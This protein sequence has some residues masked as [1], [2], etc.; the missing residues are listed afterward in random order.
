MPSRPYLSLWYKRFN[1][2]YSTDRP[3]NHS[4][5]GRSHSRA[6]NS[7]SIHPASFHHYHVAVIEYHWLKQAKWKLSK[8]SK[9]GSCPVTYLTWWLFVYLLWSIT[10]K[11]E[12]TN[13]T[14][15]FNI[16]FYLLFPMFIVHLEAS[17][18]Y[19]SLNVSYAFHTLLSL[20]PYLPSMISIPHCH[21]CVDT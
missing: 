20:S 7:L 2:Y 21:C 11:E 19:E 3:L 4:L 10:P 14:F 5:K 12:Q 17:V 1:P 9:K 6:P 13:M 16:F 18:Q 8:E 15:K